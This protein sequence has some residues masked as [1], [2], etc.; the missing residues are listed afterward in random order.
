MV[1]EQLEIGH[2]FIPVGELTGDVEAARAQAQVAHEAARKNFAKAA[3]EYSRGP[4]AD[5]GG[6]LGTFRPDELSPAFQRAVAGLKPGDVSEP[7]EDENSFHIVK[8]V[9]MV[10]PERVP[11]ESV[12]T[13]LEER[14]YNDTLEARF[15]R[16]VQEDLRKRHHI[17]MQLEDLDELMDDR[18]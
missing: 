4:N 10:A 12:R 8:V 2:I 3:A 14:L 11:L 5:E 18:S 1:G 6:I 9:R 16:W 17:T 13:E 7:F 15:R